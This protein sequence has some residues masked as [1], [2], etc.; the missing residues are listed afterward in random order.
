MLV[1]SQSEKL[2]LQILRGVGAL[3]INP[4]TGARFCDELGRRD[5]VTAR[6]HEQVSIDEFV[7]SINVPVKQDRL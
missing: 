5:Y 4:L 7:P 1:R 6:M 3:L 2:L